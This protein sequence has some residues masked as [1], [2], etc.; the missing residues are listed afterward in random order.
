[1]KHIFKGLSLFAIILLF[2]SC[3]NND[4]SK[5]SIPEIHTLE[6]GVSNNLL[7]YVGSDLHIEAEILADALIQT[8]EIKI[9]KEN[10]NWDLYL[11][12]DEFTNQRNAYFHK[13]I[14]IPS[15][16][17]IGDYHFL[18]IVKDQ[19]GN[20]TQQEVV[21]EIKLIDD[22]QSPV[23]S[24]TSKPETN[25]QFTQG[26]CI[27]ISGIASDNTSLSELLVVLVKTENNIADEQVTASNPNIIVMKNSSHL[28]NID[29]YDFDTTIKVGAPTD[30]N[31]VPKPI[32]WQSGSYYIL[33]KTKDIN[34]N[35]TYSE[36][37]TIE[38]SL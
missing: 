27:E 31:S 37:F 20:K 25:R 36:R 19:E 3:N 12:Y 17:E 15:G 1:M 22:R 29:F 7:G 16:T 34:G 13:H 35:T 11:I 28:H 33:V 24:I 8:V 4:N 18:F 32:L 21:I 23:L 2:I 9:F 38:I 26:E 10:G 30:N 5:N 14:D 6:V